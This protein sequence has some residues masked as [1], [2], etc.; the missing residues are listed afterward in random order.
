MGKECTYRDEKRCLATVTEVEK[1]LNII[2]S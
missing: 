1:T 2:P